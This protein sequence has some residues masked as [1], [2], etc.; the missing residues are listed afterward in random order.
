MKLKP[1]EK[2]KSNTQ[3]MIPVSVD[4]ASVILVEVHGALGVLIALHRR[5][6]YEFGDV[7]YFRLCN[8]EPSAKFIKSVELVKVRGLW[9]PR[10]S[11]DDTYL[12]EPSKLEY[13]VKGISNAEYYRIAD[14]VI[15]Y[16]ADEV[17]A[18]VKLLFR[19]CSVFKIAEDGE[20][21]FPQGY[22]SGL[23]EMVSELDFLIPPSKS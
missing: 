10:I 2:L 22:A 23:P 20:L 15:G 14:A 9:I 5:S 7:V 16:R 21:I 4:E 19:N 1:Q 3:A 13:Q 17:V 8:G 11:G 18:T 6:D 12:Y